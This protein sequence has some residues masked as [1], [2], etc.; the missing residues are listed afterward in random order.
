VWEFTVMPEEMERLGIDCAY[1]GEADDI[2]GQLLTHVASDGERSSLFH[3][4][5]QTFDD[6]FHRAFVDDKRF[7]SRYQFSKQFP[8]LDEIPD[9]VNPS[10]KGMIEVMRGCGI[11][12]DFCEVTLRPL[13]YYPPER[14]RREVEV[15]TKAGLSHAWLHSDEIFAY[16]HGTNFEPN[17]EALSEL[18]SVV[19]GTPGLTYTNPTHGRISIPAAY[20]ELMGRLSKVLKAGPNNWIGVQVGIETGSDRLA[21]IH[22]PNKTL[23]LKVGPDGSWAEIVWRGTYIMNKYYWRPAFT[24]QV[25]Q[26]SETPE[27]N[28]ETV[29]LINA[30]SNSDVAGRPFEFTATPM[31][32]VP[33]GK[34][35][36]QEFSSHVLDPSQLAV[37]YA[38]YRHLYKV[39]YRNARSPKSN[40]TS[41]ALGIGTGAVL[42]LGAWAMLRLV[43]GVC[44]KGGLDVEKA[45]RYGLDR[46]VAQTPLL[47]S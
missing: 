20:P 33:L 21:A 44:K 29:A 12:C 26:G 25:G 11:A 38:C 30:M 6:Q 39:A 32:N 42:A 45:A 19:M 2:I 22:M 28:W 15:N 17:A 24:V 4:G 3:G 1:Q 37:Y 27:D 10:V 8:T 47:A 46:K 16:Q 13:R 14:V 5:F 36:S 18:F 35:K 23:P 43:T 31:Q 7:L 34:I 41:S 40:G 9:I